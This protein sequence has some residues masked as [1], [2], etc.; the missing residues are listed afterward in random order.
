MKLKLTSLL[1]LFISLTVFAKPI[2][3]TDLDKVNKYIEELIKKDDPE[4]KYTFK[5]VN[6]EK[7]ADGKIS[8]VDVKATFDK[9]VKAEFEAGLKLQGSTI[10]VSAL[11]SGNLTDEMS[12][13]E[14]LNI[15]QLVQVYGAEYIKSINSKGFYKA[16][17]EVTMK[18]DK[19]T[20][21]FKMIPDSPDAVSI[22]VLDF[23][24]E[25]DLKTK[26]ITGLFGADLNSTADMV[27]KGQGALTKI[28]N[29]LM[30]GEEPKQADLDEL[31]E[32]INEV[33][34]SLQADEE[35]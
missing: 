12:R 1:L 31:N 20:A 16:T 19:A 26:D 3:Q 23:S 27:K 11:V 28:F 24:V 10:D 33:F 14:L 30:K 7:E 17:L 6:A 2:A 34:K 21:D 22:N 15:I 5:V 4:D 9:E 8:S 25:V 29:S 32:V 13:E 18:G 35:Y